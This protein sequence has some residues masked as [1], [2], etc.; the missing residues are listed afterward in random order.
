M[1]LNFFFLVIT[2]GDSHFCKTLDFISIFLY[3]KKGRCN[4]SKEISHLIPKSKP[5]STL[6]KVHTKS[7]ERKQHLLGHNFKFFVGISSSMW[8][9]LYAVL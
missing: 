2:R 3:L 5:S 6:T 8:V 1:N 9:K 7:K 4:F